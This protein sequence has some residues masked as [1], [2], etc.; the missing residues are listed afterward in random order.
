MLVISSK[1][2]ILHVCMYGCPRG[3]RVNRTEYRVQ[4]STVQYSTVQYS[5]VQYSTV[6]YSTVQ[7]SSLQCICMPRRQHGGILF[8]ERSDIMSD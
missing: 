6:Q 5:T 1:N 7:Y 3:V 2:W 8:T 4:Y